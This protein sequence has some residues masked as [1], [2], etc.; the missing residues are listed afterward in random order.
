MDRSLNWAE[1]EFITANLGDARLKKRLIAITNAFAGNP[2]AQITQ[3]TGNW[4]NAKATYRFFD[5]QKVTFDNIILPHINSTKE[6]LKEYREEQ[7]VL[8]VQ[9]T[10][11]QKYWSNRERL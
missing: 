11:T 5:N 8:V 1:K 4:A 6:R 10:S 3:A 2:L 9:D 7:V